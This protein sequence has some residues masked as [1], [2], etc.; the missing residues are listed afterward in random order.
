MAG[1]DATQMRVVVHVED[2][3]R[4]VAFYRDGL[5]FEEAEAY[6]GPSGA[7]VMI[8]DVGRATLELANTAQVEFIDQVEVGERVAPGIRIAFEVASARI[9][10][11]VAVAAGATLIAAPIETPWRSLNSRLEGEA[12]LQLTLFEELGTG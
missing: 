8:L 10:T 12:G 4:A 11:D 1:I 3:D 5:G 7:E 2:F 9:A 6:S